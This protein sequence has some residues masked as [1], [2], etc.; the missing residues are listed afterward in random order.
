MVA[1]SVVVQVGSGEDT[2]AWLMATI[3]WL[4][5][6]VEASCTTE[7]RRLLEIDKFNIHISEINF[8]NVLN[9]YL[10]SATSAIK[11]LQVWAWAWRLVLFPVTAATQPE[12]QTAP[13]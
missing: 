2:V 3:L 6:Q 4:M 12:G 7:Q 11:P 13:K 8:K 5:G 1:V 10:R 9:E